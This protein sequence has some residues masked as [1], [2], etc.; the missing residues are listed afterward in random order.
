MAC[1]KNRHPSRQSRVFKDNFFSLADY[2]NPEGW[3]LA[4]GPQRLPGGDTLPGSAP[5]TA[6]K[7]PGR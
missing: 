6:T 1:G 2:L 3:C 5:K 4:P 7:A